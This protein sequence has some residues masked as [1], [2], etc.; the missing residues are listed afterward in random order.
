[1]KKLIKLTS[2]GL[3]LIL[4]LTAC[5]EQPKEVSENTNEVV[6]NE[7]VVS[8]NGKDKTKEDLKNEEEPK[9]EKNQSEINQKLAKLYN[10]V[11]DDINSYEFSDVEDGKYTYSYALVK[12]DES[13]Y[14]NL[15]VAQDTDF[16][17]SYLKFFTAND[18]YTDVL[19][20]DEIISVGVASAGGF[21]G[22]IAQNADYDALNYTTFMSGT[23][24]GQEVKITT[25]VEDGDLKLER[26]VIWEGRIDTKAQDESYEIEFSEIED[27]D[28][29][30][31]LSAIKDGEYV[32]SLEEENDEK[33]E[34]NEENKEVP[35]AS[36]KEGES[37][38]SKIQAEKNLGNMVATGSVRVFSHAELLDYQQVNPK[39]I[40]D[41]GI[42][43]A[44]LLLD[45]PMD[46]AI[47]SGA[48]DGPITRNVDMIG[49]PEDMMNYDGQHIT[50]SFGTNDGHWQSDASLPVGAPRMH[51][52]K[53]LEWVIN[54]KKKAF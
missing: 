50:I 39:A 51:Q 43:Y 40:P 16:G 53:V 41:T 15:L 4:S 25:S 20:D 6:E 27:R 9:E 22:F 11:L 26:E 37:L 28:K 10:D 18:D 32:K 54:N 29:I 12:T 49:L 52:V 2:L 35:S 30:S 17:L 47:Q 1:M 14:P 19:Y 5:S 36:Q 7:E 48:G 45:S 21:R 31:D 46:V 23:G 8:D 13:D 24:E 34:A 42:N 3:V 33:E 44:I 38:E